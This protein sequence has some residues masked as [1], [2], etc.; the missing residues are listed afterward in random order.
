MIKNALFDVIDACTLIVF[1]AAIGMFC[2]ALG[3]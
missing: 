2:L 3:A 1:V